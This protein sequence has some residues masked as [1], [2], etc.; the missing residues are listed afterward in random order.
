[1]EDSKG[2]G[3]CCFFPAWT[4]FLRRYYSLLSLCS[5][6]DSYFVVILFYFIFFCWRVTCT[7]RSRQCPPRIQPF[8][9]VYSKHTTSVMWWLRT[10]TFN[11]ER[12]QILPLPLTGCLV[13]G[14]LLYFSVPLYSQPYIGNDY[15]PYLTGLLW[16]LKEMIHVK[17]LESHLV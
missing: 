2:Q 7:Y 9:L 1:M 3:G 4:L 14:K 11:P 6:K 8:Q 12:V 13:L 10:W 16:R 15:I 5:Y 17:F